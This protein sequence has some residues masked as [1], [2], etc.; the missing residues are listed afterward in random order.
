[1]TSPVV[2]FWFD[3]AST[4]SYPACM[5]ADSLVEQAGVTLRYRP[6]LLGPIFRAQSTTVAIIAPE[7]QG[8]GMPSRSNAKPPAPATATMKVCAAPERRAGIH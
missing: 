6:F 7:S 3:F 2:D 8:A 1:M 5:R 4:Y